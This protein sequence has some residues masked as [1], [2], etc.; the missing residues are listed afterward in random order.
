MQRE[1]KK[2][3]EALAEEA[4]KVLSA[5]TEHNLQLEELENQTK[6]VESRSVLLSQKLLRTVKEIQEDGRNAL[7][8]VLTVTF[9]LLFLYVV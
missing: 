2:E 8:A 3:T 4:K 1:I 9:V 5:I 7:I 6:K